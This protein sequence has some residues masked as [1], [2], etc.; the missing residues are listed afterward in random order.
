M[1]YVQ[2]MHIL[3]TMQTM[4]SVTHNDDKCH[5]LHGP[6]WCMIYAG[7]FTLSQPG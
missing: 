1:H 5:L 6:S 4:T 7:K 3:H 2:T